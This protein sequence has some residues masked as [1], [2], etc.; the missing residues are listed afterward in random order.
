MPFSQNYSP[1]AYS[2]IAKWEPEL[3]SHSTR[4]AIA[5][6]AGILIRKT[7]RRVAPDGVNCG[8]KGVLSS[9]YVGIVKKRGGTI[10]MVG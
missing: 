6:L 7:M 5:F 2:I 8:S 3:Q 10:Y 1:V 9:N 4:S